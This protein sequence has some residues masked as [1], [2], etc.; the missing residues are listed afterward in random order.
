[1][2]SGCKLCSD[3][4]PRKE[5]NPA[6]VFSSGE[7]EED[8]KENGSRDSNENCYCLAKSHT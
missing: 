2:H 5:I 6:I 8:L 7:V 3:S 1:M 4:G